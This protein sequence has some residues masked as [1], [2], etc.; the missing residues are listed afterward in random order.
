M[1]CTVQAEHVCQQVRAQYEAR[2][3]RNLSRACEATQSGVRT[4]VKRIRH[5]RPNQLGNAAF[6]WVASRKVLKVN[7]LRQ[8]SRTTITLTTLHVDAMTWMFGRMMQA[9]PG[10][11]SGKIASC[12][13]YRVYM[14]YD[15]RFMTHVMMMCFRMMRQ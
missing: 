9:G 10:F 14:I 4:G 6:A 1:Y 15:I 12:D 7:G 11:R 2:G 3:G 8:K 5:Q 13:I